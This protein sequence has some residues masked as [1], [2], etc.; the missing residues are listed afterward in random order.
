MD[1]LKKLPDKIYLNNE[2][3][4]ITWCEDRITNE[5]VVYIKLSETEVALERLEKEF[6]KAKLD[7]LKKALGK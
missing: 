5:D 6:K 3:G 1:D 7:K 4:E 2:L